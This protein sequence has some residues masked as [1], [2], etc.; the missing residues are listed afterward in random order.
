MAYKSGSGSI[1]K[2]SSSL[3]WL[4]RYRFNQNENC[5]AWKS[6][7]VSVVSQTE[8]IGQRCSMTE[9]GAVRNPDRL[10]IKRQTENRT[11]LKPAGCCVFLPAGFNRF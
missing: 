8:Y 4:I 11:R 5:C 6:V 10:A 7:Q 1:K 9:A 3:N 2:Q